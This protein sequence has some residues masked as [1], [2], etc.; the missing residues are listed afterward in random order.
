MTKTFE[1]HDEAALLDR[2][3]TGLKRRS[4]EVIFL[5]GAPLSAPLK[6]GNP[7]VPDVNG[8]IELI[9]QEFGSAPSEKLVLEAQLA[10]S[11]KRIYHVAFSFL[12]GRR[13][14]QTA[15]EIVSRAVLSA[16]KS[17]T[18]VPVVDFANASAAENALRALEAD[19]AGWHLNP[20]TAAL[21]KLVAHFFNRF[22]KTLLT[23][24]FDPLIEIAIRQE[25]APLYKTFLHTDGNLGQ[26]EAP[27]SHI[28]H[29][30]GS[31]L[32]TDTLHTARQL[33]QPRPH[34]KDSLRSLLRNKLVVTCAYGGWD[35]VFME[36][37]M[38]VVRDVNACP[39]V[40]WT[41]HGLNPEPNNDLLAQL[42]VGL[43]RGRINLYAGIDC[44]EFFP[45]LYDR[46]I[47]LEPPGVAA[48][49]LQ[50]NPVRVG[51]TLSQK[52]QGRP[53]EQIVIEGD[54]EDTPPAIDI[55]L[56][57]DREL[58]EINDS[59]AKVL[60]LTGIG[61]Q[62]KSTVAAKYFVLSQEERRYSYYVWRDC[63]EESER[64][65]NQLTSVIERLSGGRISGEDLAKQDSKSIIEIL[66]PLLKDRKVLFVFD[67]VD[68]YV[69]L[70][71]AK[72][73]GAAD[74]FIQALLRSESTSRA[75]FTC[76]PAVTYE[77]S[78]G[79]NIH[80][81][82]IGIDAA[83]ELFSR[84]GAPSTFAEIEEAHSLT[85]GH[86][87]WL[88]LLAIQAGKQHEPIDLATLISQ[89]GSSSELEEQTLRSIW[90]TLR[91]REQTILRA[92]AVSIRPSA[93]GEIAEYVSDALNY[94]KVIKSLRNLRSLNLIVIKERSH[95]PNL[96]E[97]HPLVRKFV[98][99]NFPHAER[100]GIINRV[101]GVYQKLIGINRTQLQYRPSLVVLQHWTQSAELDVYAGKFEEAFNTLG[102][103]SSAFIGSAYP[104]EFARP[105]GLLFKGVDWVA[106]FSQFKEFDRVFVTYVRILDEIGR[107]READEMLAKY[108]LTVP[109]RDARYILYCDLRCYSTWV[110]GDFVTA[111]Q[112]GNR[113]HQLK[114]SSKVDTNFDV[115]HNL[116]L[117]ERDAGRPEVALSIFLSGRNLSDVIDPEEFDDN[118]HGHYYGNIGRCLHLM[119]QVDS[120]L[121]CYQKSALLLE[122]AQSPHVVNEG[123][124]RAW[125][126]ELLLTRQQVALAYMFYRAAY[127]K[128]QSTAPPRAM[129]IKQIM[130]QFKGKV[131]GDGVV[132]D[133]LIERAWIDWTRGENVDAEFK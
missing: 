118:R 75:V 38:D 55:F 102:E 73:T 64:F 104:R 26:T 35:D 15:N 19:V 89:I 57:R 131:K 27:G 8:M 84:R 107:H 46:W 132:D 86:A 25:G 88:D 90:A 76:R 12:Q 119:G 81:E 123:F 101:I 30:H 29:L 44:N 39:E 61:G 18:S 121:V 124:I 28:V 33:G 80:L 6:P 128:W 22:G 16:R 83:V 105:A 94:N 120:A 58:K 3:S 92:M 106:N 129:Q 103:V 96:F 2:L 95:A 20:G 112:W 40:L 77:D 45:R 59:G 78:G 69:D 127:L 17:G 7:G 93:E 1:F 4:Q 42:E 114:L 67:N 82:G 24:N 98:S 52:V 60:L 48:A 36:A 37:L 70:E 115:S 99:R 51:D 31:W 72:M 133:I 54:D 11:G 111:V 13:G 79:L 100:I 50:S 41:F 91:E 116:A 56:G 71:T 5:V 34:L 113:G 53:Q 21:G 117:A 68:H 122:S 43:N 85:G 130:Q 87:F 49:P 32:G 23:T 63:K 10:T 9:R 108:E 74:S 62:G 66:L 14:Q 97:L 126:A 65:E 125:V 109:N 47:T 110:R